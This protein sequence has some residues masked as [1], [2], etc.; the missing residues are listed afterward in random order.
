M[1]NLIIAGIVIVII[2]IIVVA[3]YGLTYHTAV[4]VSTST[5]TVPFSSTP[6]GVSNTGGGILA[7][8]CTS[9]S[10]FVCSNASI[11]LSGDLSLALKS[12]VNATLYDVHVA[13]IAYN[14][15]SAKPVNAS[16]WYA[17]NNLGTPR[18]ANFTGTSIAFGSVEN[19]AS[20]QC[21]S[22]S[23][24]AIALGAGQPYKGLLLMNYTKTSGQE[25]SGNGWQTVG[26]AAFNVNAIQTN[27]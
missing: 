18:E 16:S 19:I 5:T 27:G 2:A 9:S 10:S 20:L 21:Y 3:A 6:V 22:A 11:T 26:V 4:V 25:G 1:E 7:E 15:I 24:N 13:C 8:G 14:S 12:N 17:L 23:G